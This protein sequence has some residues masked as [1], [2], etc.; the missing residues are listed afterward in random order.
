[1]V[2]GKKDL[3][4]T[5]SVGLIVEQCPLVLLKLLLLS[6]FN[7]IPSLDTRLYLNFPGIC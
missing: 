5:G 1:M 3:D 7:H 4:L 2:E 6:T